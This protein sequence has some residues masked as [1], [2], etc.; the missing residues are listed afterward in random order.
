MSIEKCL[1][2]NC[3]STLASL[4]TGSMFNIEYESS[5]A[6]M[7]HLTSWNQ[8]LNGKGVF[9][10]V[11]KCSEQKALIYVYRKSGLEKELREED[12]QAFLSHYGYKNFDID[13]VLSRLRLHFSEA[14]FPHE[15]GIFLGYPLADVIGF[16]ENEGKNFQCL[17]CWKVY[18]NRQEA[19]K[20]F[21][22]IRKCKAIYSDLWKQGK[23]ILQLTV[24]K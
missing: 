13:S 10:I 3:A 9:V 12:I 15:I 17:G 11:L 18:C 8:I 24:A 4:K 21:G 5:D 6:L 19:E 2:E 23:S 16:I 14:E 20:M 1:V 22:K 7:N